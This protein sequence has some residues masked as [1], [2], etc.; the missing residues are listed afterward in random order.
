[1]QRLLQ[2][3]EELRVVDDQIGAPTSV[4]ALA[5]AFATILQQA[6]GNTWCDWMDA[7]TGVYHMT[8]GGQTSWFGFASAIASNL[9]VQ[10]KK[11]ARLMP[12][13]TEEYPTPASRPHWSVL[14]NSK[15]QQTFGVSLPGWHDALEVVLERM[16][17]EEK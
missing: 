3:R 13:K 2:E 4:I 8:C 16:S 14:D 17:V 6:E 1:M 12:I 5:T 9:Q 11:I 7:Y 15:L 10:G